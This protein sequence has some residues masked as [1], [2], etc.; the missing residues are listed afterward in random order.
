VKSL[1]KVFLII[2]LSLSLWC[3]SWSADPAPK[4]PKG[5]NKG[6]YS[7]ES[8]RGLIFYNVYAPQAGGWRVI[9]WVSLAFLLFLALYYRKPLLKGAQEVAYSSLK[10]IKFYPWAPR[11]RAFKKFSARQAFSYWLDPLAFPNGKVITQ[12][13]L[14]AASDAQ[15]LKGFLLLE[16]DLLYLSA[17][18][19][20]REM[21]QSLI[22]ETDSESLLSL[23]RRA[24]DRIT[25]FPQPKVSLN[26]FEEALKRYKPELVFIETP[27]VFSSPAGLYAHLSS[28]ALKYNIPLVVQLNGELPPEFKGWLGRDS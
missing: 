6:E 17:H 10:I 7:R 1:I 9:G 12:P 16:R 3:S 14:F 5:Y 21:L 24:Q 8:L 26:K 27:E 11:L 25:F 23:F 2:I 19:G 20:E 15:F 18:Q 4:L 13:G 28:L 22:S